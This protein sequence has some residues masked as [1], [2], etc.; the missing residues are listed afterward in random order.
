MSQKVAKNVFTLVL[1]KILAAILV[2]LGYAALFRYLG[3]FSTG[4]YTFALSY[5]M[6]FSIVVDFGIQQLVI[7]KVSENLEESKK[8]LANFFAIEVLLA[9]VVYTLLVGIA[10]L[11]HYDNLV[12][13]A[14]VVAGFGMFLNALSIPYTAII[15]AHQDMHKIALVN[16]FDSVINVALMFSAIIF[17]RS[18]VFLAT[19][20]VF[21]GIMHLAVY[22]VMIRKYISGLNPFAH[23]R[24]V[25]FGLIKKMIVAALPFG[26]LVGFSI[27]YNKID[28]LILTALR[29]YAE[30]GLY[31]AAYKFF[32]VLAF[33]PAVVSSS[34][35]PFFSESIKQGNIEAVRNAL[36]KY[37]K[38]MIGIAMP[39]AF[40]GAVLAP[41][42][43]LLV[44]GKDFLP[45]YAA[46]EIL[47][48]ASATLFIYSA[49]NSLMINQLTRLA[50]GI[51]FINIFVNSI[52][53]L[54]LIPH[55]GFR[56][57]A[58]MTLVSELVQAFFYFYFVRSHITNFKFFGS[59]V[60]PT[61]CAFLMAALLYLLKQ[62]SLV[63]TL[64]LGMLSYAIFIMLSGFVKPEDLKIVRRFFNRSSE[65]VPAA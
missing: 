35:Y 18:I 27:I 47:V 48:F 33:L 22:N 11:N 32:D 37:T 58:A 21:M 24:F 52:G 31:T 3:T 64:P 62:H 13:S 1:S 16:F 12:F 53:N 8:Y 54:L 26:A 44:A 51:T 17:H 60:K 63:L 56:A 57:A 36:A 39:I 19:V 29:G 42:L 23:L 30:T 50:V 40:G 61:I 59:F 10:Y 43:I 46:I 55:F 20:Q 9:L 49:V 7:K 2:F 34:L 25:E 6:L 41:K 38:Y 15:S 4:E 45:G 28:V 65:N 14:I 5:V